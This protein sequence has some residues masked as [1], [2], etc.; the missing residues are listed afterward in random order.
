MLHIDIPTL[1]EFKALA[2]SKDNISISI[3]VPTSPLHDQGDANRLAFKDLARDAISQLKTADADKDRIALI[4]ER[5]ERMSGDGP[6]TTDDKKFRYREHDPAEQVDEF[7]SHQ[8][9][10]LAVL[11]TPDNMRMF[12]LPN[13]PIPLAEVADRFHLTPLIRAMSSPHDIYV[14]ALAEEAVRLVHVFVNLPPVVVMIPGL[15]KGAA[16]ATRRPSIHVRAPRGRL[17]NREGEKVLLTKYVRAVDHAVCGELASRSPPLVLVAP[18]PIA[19]IFRSVSSYSNLLGEGLEENA[20]HISDAQLADKALPF[21]DRL[22]AKE[23]VTAFDHYDE[24]KPRRAT[25]DI[26]HAARAATLGAVDELLV[27]LDAVIPG[28]VDI[29]GAVTYAATDDAGAYSV[30]DEVARRSLA[31]GAKVLGATRRELPENAPLVAILRFAI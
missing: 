25:T 13:K 27:D 26:S 16:E 28:R 9:N 10:G 31:F 17:Q 20:S 3:Y 1:G 29:D 18:E 2:A 14:L 30:V 22:Y 23:L 5:F 24:L 12:R 7:W 4:E 19:S 15:P 8:A 6:D 11:T 21:L